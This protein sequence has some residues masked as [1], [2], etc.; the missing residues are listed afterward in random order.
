MSFADLEKKGFNLDVK[1]SHVLEVE[2]GYSSVELLGMLH[3]SFKKSDDLLDSL[4]KELVNEK[5]S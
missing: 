5:L 2:R 4:K 1:N 3:D